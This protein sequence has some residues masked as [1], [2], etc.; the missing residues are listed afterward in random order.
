MK[1]TRAATA[2]VIGLALGATG[3]LAATPT[4]PASSNASPVST[5]ARDKTAVGGTNDNHGGAVSAVAQGQG[6]ADSTST[7]GTTITTGAQGTHGAAVS[8]V[9]KDPTQVG[10]KNNN[11]GGAVSAVARGSHGPKG[12]HPNSH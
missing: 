11:H 3:V 2:A 7:T 6:S 4:A 1:T 8:L 12:S 9:A 5:V 10:G